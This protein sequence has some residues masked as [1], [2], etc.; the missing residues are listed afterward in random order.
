MLVASTTLLQERADLEALAKVPALL[1]DINVPYGLPAAPP[2]VDLYF[3]ISPIVQA[4]PA[5]NVVES[6]ALRE[7]FMNI[8]EAYPHKAVVSQRARILPAAT[9]IAAI[10]W[11]PRFGDRTIAQVVAKTILARLLKGNGLVDLLQR[12]HEANCP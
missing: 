6:F 5:A 11:W 10:K 7:W 4:K 2:L 3:G 8:A 12:A 1:R 9:A